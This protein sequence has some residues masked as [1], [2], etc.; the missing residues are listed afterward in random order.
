MQVTFVWEPPAS[1][2]GDPV[3]VAASR[4]ELT[5]LGED[6]RVLFEGPV[7]PTGP[8]VLDSA[9]RESARAVFPAEPGRLRLRMKI[10]DA[11]RRQVDSDVRDI[12]VRDLRG[13]VAIAT[14]EFLRARNFREF[15]TL[16]EPTAVPVSSREFRRTE[17]LLIRFGAHAP[18]G[19]QP[20]VTA[21]L[22]NRN[23]QQMR[24]L[25]VRSDGAR[26]EVDLTLAALASGEYHLELSATT[27]SGD[28]KEVL[29]FRVTN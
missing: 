18:D 12:I 3:R 24:T 5:V 9:G 25:D 14:P 11:E 28:A 27:P 2:P 1:V 16:A 4:V 21:R 22:L 7:R 20:L 10:E 17:R 23:G 19:E 13:R 8:G 26:R 6:D 15:R 29:G